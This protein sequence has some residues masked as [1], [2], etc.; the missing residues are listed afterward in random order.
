LTGLGHASSSIAG[1]WPE[2]CVRPAMRMPR[3]LS[4]SSLLTKRKSQASG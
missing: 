3:A 2:A 1:W 4:L